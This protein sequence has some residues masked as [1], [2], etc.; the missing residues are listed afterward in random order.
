MLKNEVILQKSEFLQQKKFVNLKLTKLTTIL[1]Q[2]QNLNPN[3]SKSVFLPSKD[4]FDDIFI[5]T[6]FKYSCLECGPN[7][8][9]IKNLTNYD[10]QNFFNILNQDILSLNFNFS[11]NNNLSRTLNRNR[12]SND[13]KE[14]LNYE[15]AVLGLIKLVYLMTKTKFSNEIKKSFKLYFNFIILFY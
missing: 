12:M 1:D 9:C 11:I 6:Q 14:Y 7:S 13:A 4:S 3:L 8:K 15:K 10:N 2:D 5:T